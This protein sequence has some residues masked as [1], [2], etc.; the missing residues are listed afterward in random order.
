MKTIK[1]LPFTTDDIYHLESEIEDL[2]CSQL[3]P[4]KE[5][6]RIVR[7][8]RHNLRFMRSVIR[9]QQWCVRN[10]LAKFQ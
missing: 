2:I 8:I 6:D 3:I 9:A 1:K 4:D 10:K 7:Q 5:R